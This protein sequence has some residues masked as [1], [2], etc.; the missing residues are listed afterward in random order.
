MKARYTMT[1]VV[2][3]ELYP[4]NFP[5]G[6][7]PEEMLAIDCDNFEAAP[8]EML[9]WD[10][11]E[12][13]VAGELIED[14]WG[15]VQR[16]QVDGSFRALLMEW[17]G[18]KGELA[19]AKSNEMSLRK[20]ISNTLFPDGREG[21]NK[22]FVDDVEVSAVLKTNRSVDKG[23]LSAYAEEFREYNINVDALITYKPELKV[24]EYRKLSDQQRAVFNQALTISE[25][26]PDIKLVAGKR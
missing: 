25:G 19:K 8:E 23:R 18:Q 11:A 9:A 16:A 20:A 22:C 2:E 14:H 26:A 7:T 3:T 5:E 10:T 17:E 21:T 13:N 1:I 12:V 24:G 15:T 4:D 6:S